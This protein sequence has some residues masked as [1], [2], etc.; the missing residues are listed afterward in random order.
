[1]S[2]PQ[3]LSEGSANETYQ[4]R[5]HEKLTRV[6]RLMEL[7]SQPRFWICRSLLSLNYADNSLGG[8]VITKISDQIRRGKRFMMSTMTRP[9]RATIDWTMEI[10]FVASPIVGEGEKVM[11]RRAEDRCR[12]DLDGVRALHRY[13][14]GDYCCWV[15]QLHGRVSQSHVNKKTAGRR[16]TVLSL[17]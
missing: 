1:M 17:D 15:D 9:T 13:G 6:E 14:R 12:Y 5:R 4:L 10:V 3:V 2:G 7:G 16:P 8:P 11:A